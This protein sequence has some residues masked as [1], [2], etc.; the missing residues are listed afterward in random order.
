MRDLPRRTITA[1]VYAAVVLLALAAPPIVFWAI[2]AVVGV[3]GALEFAALRTTDEY[4]TRA[5]ELVFF[6][7][8]VCLG[9]LRQLGSGGNFFG[10]SDVPVLLVVAILPT[11]AADV[12]AYLVG[13]A[14]GKRKLAPRISPGKTWEGTAAGFVAAALVVVALGLVFHLP[15]GFVVLLALAVGPLALAG[16]LLESAMKRSAGVKDSGTIFP[17]HGGVLDRLDSLVVVS[18]FVLLSTFLLS[19][20]YP[21]AAG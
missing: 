18:I 11:W 20:A 3:L 10:P 21:S 9:G 13:S 4:V 7:G 6:V 17:G 1:V 5:F 15:A 19:G 14:I 8:L 12:V 16:D 2:L